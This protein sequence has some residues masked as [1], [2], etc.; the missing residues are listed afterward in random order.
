MGAVL[1]AAMGLLHRNRRPVMVCAAS[2]DGHGGLVRLLAG[3]CGTKAA[4]L[5]KRHCPGAIRLRN[6][7][8]N[9]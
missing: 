9:L 2:W 1:R 4:A 8:G 7:F 6:D 5:P 3:K